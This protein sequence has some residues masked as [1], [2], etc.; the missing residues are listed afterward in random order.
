MQDYGDVFVAVSELNGTAVK[1]L[2][3]T[4]SFAITAEEFGI[5]GAKWPG[6]FML[7]REQEARE[8]IQAI[9][10]RE[11]ERLF[12]WSKEHDR[13][14]ADVRCRIA[15]NTAQSCA[16]IDRFEKRVLAVVDAG[17]KLSQQERDAAFAGLEQ[18]HVEYRRLK[19]EESALV[20]PLNIAF[21]FPRNR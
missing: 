5:A 4:E 13:A 21:G 10:E 14:L 15:E 8:A 9:V 11:E 20:D 16:Y 1:V 19:A 2:G 12:S 6:T 7:A 17:G 18:Y 3:Y